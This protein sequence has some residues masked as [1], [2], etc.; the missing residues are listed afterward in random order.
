MD[1]EFIISQIE[2]IQDIHKQKHLISGESLDTY[3]KLDALKKYIIGQY[4]SMGDNQ[5]RE[6]YLQSTDPQQ[7]ELPLY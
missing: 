6:G 4:D 1:L 7:I 5:G 2:E 3:Y